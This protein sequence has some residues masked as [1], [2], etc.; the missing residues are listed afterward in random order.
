MGTRRTNE[1]AQ[2]RAVEGVLMPPTPPK[3]HLSNLQAIRREMCRVY[4][5]M[6]SGVLDVTEGNKLIWA[7]SAIG[8]VTKDALLEE[9]L[10]ELERLATGEPSQPELLEYEDEEE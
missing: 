6:A 1:T 3:I 9:R 5:L 10:D 8:T 7:L 2:S 4:R